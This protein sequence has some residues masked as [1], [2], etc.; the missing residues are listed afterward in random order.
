MIGNSRF[1]KV[2]VYL[3][4]QLM[5]GSEESMRHLLSRVVF[6]SILM[7]S[8]QAFASEFKQDMTTVAELDNSQSQAVIGYSCLQGYPSAPAKVDR[9]MSR[10]EVAV[11]LNACLNEIDE[12]F[13]NGAANLA[14]TEDLTSLQKQQGQ[15]N[16]DLTSLQNRLSNLGDRTEQLEPH[17]F[18]TTTKMTAQVGFSF[19]TTN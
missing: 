15:Q 6:A 9:A 12:R 13:S 17:Q 4:H 5:I 11:S 1:L 3:K 8:S 10:S 16:Q 18:S 7:I 2:V 14:P 19:S